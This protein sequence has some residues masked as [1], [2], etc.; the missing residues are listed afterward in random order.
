MI[1]GILEKL[2][3]TDN[4]VLYILLVLVLLVPLVMP[5]GL[6]MNITETTQT[7]FDIL[8]SLKAGD[9]VAFDFGYYADGAPDVE[10]QA[11]AILAHLLDKG[12]RVVA[13]SYKS[14]GP[15]IVDRLLE[16]YEAQG[17]KYGTDFVNLGYLAGAET[18]L[19]TYSRDIKKAFPTDWRGQATE[20]M[21]IL[22]GIT[23]VSDLDLYVF[24]TDGTADIWVRQISQYGTP[25]IAGL[26]TVSAPAAEP[27]LHSNQI[28]GMMVGLRGAAE[29]ELWMKKPGS[30]AAGMDA[31]SMGHILIILFIVFGNVSYAIKRSKGLAGKEV[32]R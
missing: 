13:F 27:F 8:D 32:G 26:I 19:A 29:Y 30:A 9:T 25:M 31:Q 23:S 28:A 5:L 11:V 20:S 3:E 10:P 4:R 16:P 18:A 24:F 1:L 22:Q 6:P 2:G 21:S 17:M 15:M 7:S 12:V 14:H